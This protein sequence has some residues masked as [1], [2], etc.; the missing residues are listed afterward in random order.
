MLTRIRYILLALFLGA[1]P[2]TSFGFVEITIAPPELPVYEQ[3]PCPGDGYIWTPG[4]WA[5]GDDGYYWVPGVWVEPPRVGVL[6][7]PGYWGFAGN[8]YG[9]HP[10]YW[11]P[12]V[13]Y[14]G[15]I[16]YGFGYGGAGFFGGEWQGDVYRYNTAVTRVDTTV[17]RN[18]Y[19]NNT[20]INNSNTTTRASFNG[21]GGVT[22]KPTA[23]EQ[24]VSQE[25]HIAA[26]TA[27]RNHEQ[28]AL[29]DKSQSA[30][31]NNGQPKTTALTSVKGTSVKGAEQTQLNKSRVNQNQPKAN[32]SA[33]KTE[34]KAI[35]REQINRPKSNPELKQEKSVEPKIHE[36][37]ALTNPETHHAKEPSG[38]RHEA[39]K[40]TEN[41]AAPKA[42]GEKRPNEK[43]EKRK[44]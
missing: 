43:E 22:A 41:K 17:V 31:A 29:H 20:V 10:G 6:W 3:P 21:T 42:H 12:H 39:V 35:G 5:Y 15:G 24:K 1:I 40:P 30:S 36:N 27:Q 25:Q 7:T 2:A 32:A 4:Y 44:E 13:G 16:N 26:T 23:E 19:V 28:S 37:K 38:P 9:W 14:Y 33:P 11:A 8:V 18:V 34:S